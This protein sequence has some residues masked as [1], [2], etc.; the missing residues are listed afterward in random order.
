M[1]KMQLSLLALLLIVCSLQVKSQSLIGRHYDDIESYVNG[2][3]PNEN[4]CRIKYKEDKASITIYF[5]QEEEIVWGYIYLFLNN[6]CI[7]E[8]FV[9]PEENIDFFYKE[10]LSQGWRYSFKS[11]QYTLQKNTKSYY[12]EQYYR[13]GY[14]CLKMYK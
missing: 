8:H 4:G 1:G 10:L 14:I 2:Q 12:G 5:I 11:D 6:R 13:L 9:V 7:E 3:C